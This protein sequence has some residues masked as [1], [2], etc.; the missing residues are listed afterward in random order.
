MWPPRSFGEALGYGLGKAADA[1]LPWRQ[2][3]DER[4]QQADRFAWQQKQADQ[5]QAN[6]EKMF[7]RESEWQQFQ[8]D[9]AVQQGERQKW[10]AMQEML[11]DI[12]KQAQNRA[13][14]AQTTKESEIP[15]SMDELLA[16]WVAEGRDR[17]DINRLIDVQRRF[18]G[19]TGAEKPIYTPAT[20][21]KLVRE[22]F[23]G[24]RARV[25]TQL[26]RDVK[27]RSESLGIVDPRE[28]KVVSV[29]DPYVVEPFIQN[30][31]PQTE[32]RDKPGWFT[33][34]TT[35][36]IRANVESA[37]YLREASGNLNY[38]GTP[39]YERAWLGSPDSLRV[40]YPGVYRN[41]VAS[42]DAYQAVYG[43]PP[44]SGPEGIR[45]EEFIDNP[46][47]TVPQVNVSPQDAIE[48]LRR[49]GVIK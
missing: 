45:W 24:A 37:R 30:Y 47:D 31:L 32:T 26:E 35:V 1:W 48:E 19:R 22:A 38:I 5:E 41:L 23:E 12:E 36:P 34:D 18:A 43:V 21:E 4:A 14:L 10:T 2:Y 16:R 29:G 13:K 39:E 28:K 42:P 33:G 49:R 15:G 6:W 44:P 25:R 27:K 8:K 20:G 40:N 17:G 3:Q 9:Q 46:A 7:G 11:L